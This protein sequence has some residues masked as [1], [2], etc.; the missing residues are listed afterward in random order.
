MGYNNQRDLYRGEQGAKAALPIWMDY[1]RTALQGKPDAPW[2]VPQ[3]VIMAQVNPATGFASSSP[4]AVSGYFLQNFPP[5]AID[6][7]I[8]L[9]ATASAP[10]G[11]VSTGSGGALIGP[12]GVPVGTSTVSV[13]GQGPGTHPAAVAQPVQNPPS[14]Q[15]GAILPSL[16]GNH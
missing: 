16:G 9:S 1:M 7:Q 3:G 2:P 13:R 4:S 11:A 14:L 12:G 5:Q 10:A 8:P 6:A 15:P